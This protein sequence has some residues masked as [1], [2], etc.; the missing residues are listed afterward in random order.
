MHLQEEV[1]INNQKFL[2]DSKCIPLVKFFN[3][4]GLMTEF[5]CE[6][7]GDAHIFRIIF[8][9][10]VTDNIIENFIIKYGSNKHQ[11]MTLGQFSNWARVDNGKFTKTWMYEAETIEDADTD[12]ELF[13]RRTT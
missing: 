12:L 3:D 2:C 11:S 5:S 7:Q 9:E 8:T 1:I 4:I 10:Q 6:S 13:K